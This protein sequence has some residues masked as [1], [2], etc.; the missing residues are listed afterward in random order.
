MTKKDSCHL[1]II[2]KLVSIAKMWDWISGFV[3]W[4]REEVC[5]GQLCGESAVRMGG[6]QNLCQWQCVV[7]Q[8]RLSNS[9][10]RAVGIDLYTSG[11][12]STN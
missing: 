10:Y 5:D 3:L 4:P 9:T 1:V 7:P 6:E 12:G 11:T 2:C 8:E